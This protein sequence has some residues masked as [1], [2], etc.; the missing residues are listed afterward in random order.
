MSVWNVIYLVIVAIGFLAFSIAV[1]GLQLWLRS[2]AATSSRPKVMSA[3][4]AALKQASVK[5]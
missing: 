3:P 1:G 5:R 2:N 4:R